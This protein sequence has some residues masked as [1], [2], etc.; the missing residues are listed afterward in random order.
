M[1]KNKKSDLNKSSY[2][3]KNQ[4]KNLLLLF[5]LIFLAILFFSVTII[6]FTI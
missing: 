1:T 4:N 5:V 3:I 6:K 2:N